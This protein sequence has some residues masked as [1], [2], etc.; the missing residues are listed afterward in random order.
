MN[1]LVGFD[2]IPWQAASPGGRFK[3]ADA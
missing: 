3:A 1:V 2:S